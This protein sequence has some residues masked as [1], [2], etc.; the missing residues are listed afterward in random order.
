[1]EYIVFERG[2]IKAARSLDGL[3]NSVFD[4]VTGRF[5]RWGRTHE[6]DPQVGPPEILD[7]EIS[8]GDCINCP[9]CYK[10]NGPQQHEHHMDLATF[11]A[12]LG[13]MPRTL[14]QI[15][16]G[17]T[18]LDSN[19]D[20][21]AMCE[22]SRQRGV[23]P[24]YTFN[25][26]QMT[27]EWADWTARTCGA[28][29]CSVYDREKSYD[30][31]KKLTDRGMK[32]V[33]IH[34]MLSEETM[35]KAWTLLHDRLHD[36]RL[37]GLN[38]IVFLAYKPKGRNR[39]KDVFHTITDISWYQGIIRHCREHNISFGCDS[40]SAPFVLKAYELMDPEEYKRV[41]GRIEPCEAS[42][43]ST[44]INCHGRYFPCSF[45]EGEGD[46]ETGV[47]VLG[48]GDFLRDVWGNAKTE[49]FR[50]ELLRSKGDNCGGC[51]SE[52][53]CRVCPT[54]RGISCQ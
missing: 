47:D 9:F 20:F 12:I 45:T 43:F 4:K 23:I 30:A 25:G 36:P 42:C 19:P 40:C 41:N 49:L 46:W 37:A 32:Q 7:L 31:I 50:Q 11:E 28:V 48:C 44:Y 13:K 15:A 18:N 51:L 8:E 38:A 54:F 34:F 5:A 33:N 21:R 22:L 27:D 52:A 29:A 6:E 1:M 17:I 24:N 2:S 35:A 39:G 16:F 14:T 26:H 10:E 53:I 3:Y